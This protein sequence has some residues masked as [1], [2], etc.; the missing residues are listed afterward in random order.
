MDQL[1]PFIWS[2]AIDKDGKDGKDGKGQ[3]DE[4]ESSR[5][6]GHESEEPDFKTMHRSK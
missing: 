2:D 1:S 6:Q 4:L 5:D 3:A